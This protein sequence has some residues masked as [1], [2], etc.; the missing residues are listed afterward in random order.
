MRAVVVVGFVAIVGEIVVEIVDAVHVG[1][2]VVVVV[3]EEI[4]L[5]AHDDYY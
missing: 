2:V 5:K 3:G 1:I 4:V